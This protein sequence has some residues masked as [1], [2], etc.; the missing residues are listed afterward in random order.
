VRTLQSSLK[1]RPPWPKRGITLAA[2]SA[3]GTKRDVRGEISSRSAT[4]ALCLGNV[5]EWYDFALYGAFATVIGP[6]FFP[7]KITPR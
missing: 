3:T 1:P 7:P 6:L 2:M 5:V 4:F